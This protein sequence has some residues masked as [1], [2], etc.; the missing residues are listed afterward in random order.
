MDRAGK[1]VALGAL[2]LAGFVGAACGVSQQ[3]ESSQPAAEGASDTYTPPREGT[4]S[5]IETIKA[6]RDP[7]GQVLVEGRLL[8][9]Q[10]TRV[11]VELYQPSATPNADPLGRAELYLGPGG[12]FEAGPFKLEGVRQVRAQVTAHFSRS[13]QPG[14][15]LALVGMNGAKLPKSALVPNNPGA[16]QS[17]GH[18]DRSQTVSID[19]P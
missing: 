1:S 18:L 17:G 12:S 5:L 15:V 4:S 3:P 11:W 14:E 7:G 6:R 13:W 19:A 10:G 8:L 2:V 9:P 16:P